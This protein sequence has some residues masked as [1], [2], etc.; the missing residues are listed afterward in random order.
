MSAKKLEIENRQMK[1]IFKWLLGYYSF[2]YQGKG[3][4][5]YYWRSHLRRRL[6]KSVLDYIK[7]N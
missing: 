4:G 3:E 1:E 2:P 7:E 6:P 5:K